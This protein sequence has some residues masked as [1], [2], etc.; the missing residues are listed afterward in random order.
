MP[1]ELFTSGVF[2]FVIAAP[3]NSYNWVVC[4][5]LGKRDEK[6]TTPDGVKIAKV[7]GQEARGLKKDSSSEFFLA[8]GRRG[9]IEANQCVVCLL[10]T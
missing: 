8:R 5:S 2:T 6:C 1:V 4:G 3:D 10:H 7:L 9:S